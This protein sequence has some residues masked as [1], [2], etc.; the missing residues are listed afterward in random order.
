MSGAIPLLPQYIFM[1]WCLVKHRENF[2]FNFTLNNN[3]T[4]KNGYRKNEFR[5]FW[6]NVTRTTQQRK[7]KLQVNA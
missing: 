7:Q 2:T 1:A 5:T 4:I 6:K 3:V